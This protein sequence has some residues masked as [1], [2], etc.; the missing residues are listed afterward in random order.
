MRVLSAV[1]GGAA[2]LGM[3]VLNTT[4][5]PQLVG[6]EPATVLAPDTLENEEAGWA[7]TTSSGL[8]FRPRVTASIPPP[9]ED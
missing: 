7:T 2:V 6:P 3:G 4:V 5:S 9:P 1:V 8:S